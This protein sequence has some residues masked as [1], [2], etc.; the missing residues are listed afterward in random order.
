MISPPQALDNSI[1]RAELC[2]AGPSRAFIPL[3]AREV[4]RTGQSQTVAPLFSAGVTH[5][6]L[7]TRM[8]HAFEMPHPA[9]PALAMDTHTYPRPWSRHN[10]CF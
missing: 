8:P 5:S 3:A 4:R 2:D 9:E 6:V 1:W 7:R 10:R